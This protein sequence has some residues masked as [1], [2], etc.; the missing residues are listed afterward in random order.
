[1][2]RA[3]LE[4]TKTVLQK[5]SFDARLFSRELKK[6]IE[7]LLPNELVELKQWL[8]QFVTDKPELQPALLYL[9]V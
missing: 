6:A 4:Y 7:R 1:M 9:P 3:M 5:V 2:A 8:V